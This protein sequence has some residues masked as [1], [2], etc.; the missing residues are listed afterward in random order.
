M[1]TLITNVSK[2]FLCTIG[3]SLGVLV[4]DSQLASATIINLDSGGSGSFTTNQSYNETRAADV[5]V[6][7]PVNLEV[8]SMTLNGIGGTGVATAVIYNT[9]TESLIASVSGTLTGGTIT[10]PISAMLVSGGDYRIGFFGDLHNGDGF[11]PSSFPYTES[12]GLLQIHG[13][14]ESLTDS[15]PSN[16][17]LEVPEVSLNVIQVPEPGS[18]TLLGMGLL[19]ALGFR[20]SRLR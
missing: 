15:F 18:L 9:S 14:W 4:F 19:G 3:V 8:T 11:L 16:V 10:L 7:S 2:K 12:S 5:T 13:A 20:R 6:L 1:K 17:N